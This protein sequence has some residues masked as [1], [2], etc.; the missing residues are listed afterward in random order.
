MESSHLH[1]KSK[2]VEHIEAESGNKVTRGRE[3]G[4]TGTCWLKGQSSSY[5]RWTRL[6]IYVKRDD[7]S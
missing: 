5:I 3:V 7:C 6:E 2:K 1:M 4:K